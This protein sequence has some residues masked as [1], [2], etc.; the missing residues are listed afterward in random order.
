MTRPARL[1][2]PLLLSGCATMSPIRTAT[3]EADP[4]LIGAES[5]ALQ[6]QLTLAYTRVRPATQVA[7]EPGG[8]DLCRYML[9]S[10]QERQSYQYARH[11]V[12]GQRD[13]AARRFQC[14]YLID[15]PTSPQVLRHVRAGIALSDLYCDTFFRRISRRWNERLFARGAVNDVGA[16]I[17]AV[18]GL[19]AA[20]SGITGAVGAATGLI[21]SS[22]RNYDNLFVVAPDLPALQNLVRER[23]RDLR[24]EI[25]GDLPTDFYGAESRII[26]YAR[27][28]SYTGMKGLLN[29]AVDQSINNRT[30][31]AAIRSAAVE[32]ATQ[33]DRDRRQIAERRAEEREAEAAAVERE[34]AAQQAIETPPP[35]P[36]AVSDP[37]SNGAGPP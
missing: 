24:R 29:A 36:A 27:L 32:A 12:Q 28:C 15:N 17:S 7:D 31:P 19:T 14:L 26:E 23:Q 20:G 8:D 2:L 30:G 5:I 10:Y 1:F 4:S 11:E 25:E 9:P 21:D 6:N 33:R 37:N 35:V 34:R 22:F 18:L 16:A 3:M 13:A